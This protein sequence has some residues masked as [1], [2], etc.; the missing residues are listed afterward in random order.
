M[1]TLVD[2]TSLNEML[3]GDDRYIKEFAEA[4][5]I[6]FN[7]FNESYKTHLTARDEENFRKAG[8]KIKPVAQ[9]LSLQVI[10]DE[11]ESGK[12]LIWDKKSDKEIQESVKKIDKLCTQVLMELDNIV[13]AD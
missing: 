4:A 7:E 11:Y 8:H 6:S 13:T 12:A 10:I 5:I 9:M 2:F 1:S 3:Y